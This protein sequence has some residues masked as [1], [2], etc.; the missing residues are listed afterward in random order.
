M[1]SDEVGPV[2]DPRIRRPRRGHRP[3]LAGRRRRRTRRHDVTAT[4]PEVQ[5]GMPLDGDALAHARPPGD[6]Y[7]RHPGDV[8]R[9]VLWGTALVLLAIFLSVAD[10]TSAGV[11]T[12]LGRVASQLPDAVREF[13]LTVAQVG[14]V[15]VPVRDRGVAGLATAVAAHRRRTAGRRGRSARVRGSRLVPRHPSTGRR[16]GRHRDLGGVVALSV[17]RLRRRRWPGPRSWASRGCLG[18]GDVRV[19]S[20]SW[21][22]CSSS[23]SLA[24][25]AWSACFSQ[26]RRAS[27]GDS[28]C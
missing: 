9:L 24:R 25:R 27:S 10:A 15:L 4:A 6:R 19:T 12:D 13:F 8:V 2:R 16:R 26:S 14:G 20:L 11:S 21:R 5:I 1:L 23:R 28:C 18:P 17:T 7:F 3:P 22:S